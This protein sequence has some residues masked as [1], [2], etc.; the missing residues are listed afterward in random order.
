MKGESWAPIRLMLEYWRV[1]NSMWPLQGVCCCWAKVV[2]VDVK[3]RE[4]IGR[5]RVWV[6]FMVGLLCLLSNLF[7]L[8]IENG[9]SF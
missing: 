9:G 5:R 3:R 8:Y 4:R 1:Q 7:R 2:V 6:V